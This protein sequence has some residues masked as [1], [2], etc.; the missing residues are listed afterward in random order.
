MRRHEVHGVRGDELGGDAQV[1]FVLAVL[2]VDDD[3]EMS[4]ADLVD[5]LLDGGERGSSSG[6]D[7][8][9]TGSS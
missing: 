7:T 6:S 3:D 8:A 1:A 4:R 9:V 2:V 5:R